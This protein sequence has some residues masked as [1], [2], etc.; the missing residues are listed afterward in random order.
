M[1]R[2]STRPFPVTPRSEW[3]ERERQAATWNDE[4][5]CYEFEYEVFESQTERI[6]LGGEPF[7]VCNHKAQLRETHQRV[8]RGPGGGLMHVDAGEVL[9]ENVEAFLATDN[10]A[11]E[12]NEGDGRWHRR[13]GAQVLDGF[14]FDRAPWIGGT[15]LLDPQ[16]QRETFTLPIADQVAEC[17]ARRLD[18]VEARQESGDKRGTTLNLQVGAED[19]NASQD[20][21]DAVSLV[22]GS[23]II[24][25][26]TEHVGSRWQNVT[27]PAGAT[28]DAATFSISIASASFDEPQHQVRGEDSDNAA[29]FTTGTNNI[30]ARPRT[31]AVTQWNS[32]DLGA[33]ANDWFEWGAPNGSPTAGANLNAIVQE[34]VDRG[35]WASGNAIV[36]IF[37]Q[38]TLD[39]LRDLQPWL[40]G[41]NSLLAPKLDI[42]YTAGAASAALT[43]TAVA[44]GVLESE[45]VAGGQTIIVTLTG[46]T[47][48]AAGATF[49][50]ARQAFID[51]LD[52]GGA[53]AGG[54][55]AVVKVGQGVAG[56]VRTSDTVVTLTLD[57]FE[58]YAISANETVT[59]TIPASILTGAAPIVATPTIPITNEAPVPTIDSVTPDSFADAETGI[60]IAGS[61][62]GAGP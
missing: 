5:K 35:G 25:S 49:N 37:E 44:G 59:A 34:I 41:G 53:E 10:L 16:W 17:I 39:A 28:I 15:E 57:A 1:V 38:H 9:L 58:S 29:A 6:R 7:F 32:A 11:Y 27:V 47:F 14:A 33:A 8:V 46:D 40:Y 51:G 30:D 60:T 52:S 21:A 19:D 45:I 2:E 26:T 24:D 62:F 50:A 20:S 48:V 18:R 12:F 54:W 23:P 61:N 55:D 13:R 22:D 3:V 42:D 4:A 36:F 56:V 43:G 31:T